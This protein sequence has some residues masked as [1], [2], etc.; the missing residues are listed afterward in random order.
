[1]YALGL[2]L[3]RCQKLIPKDPELASA[4]LAHSVH[5]LDTV[6]SDLRQFLVTLQP[7]LPNGQIL[8]SVLSEMISRMQRTTEVSLVFYA[9]GDARSALDARKSV[10]LVTV[11]REAI[12]NGLRHAR[13]QQI[14]VEL[15]QSDTEVRIEIRDDGEGFDVQAQSDAHLGL[16]NMEVRTKEIGGTFSI[17][18][19]IGA[20]TS[21]VVTVPLG[22]ANSGYDKQDVKNGLT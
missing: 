2:G 15:T 1:M 20:G 13:A 16:H 6:I 12:S 7:G 3:Q 22:E 4:Q 21:V 5:D 11:V 19:R 18:S 10:Q 17:S 8:Q 14:T 9:S